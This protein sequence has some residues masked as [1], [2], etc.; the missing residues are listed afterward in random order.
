VSNA[1]VKVSTEV[2]RRNIEKTATIKALIE[3]VKAKN[4]EITHLVQERDPS[5][6]KYETFVSM[7]KEIGDDVL[8]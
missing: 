5:K 1:L 3:E 4:V 2:A 7:A 8:K 6:R